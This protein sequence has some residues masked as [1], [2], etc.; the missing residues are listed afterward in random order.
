[1]IGTPYFLAFAVLVAAVAAVVDW[2]T[3]RIPNVLTLGALSLAPALHFCSALAAHGVSAGAT[4]AASSVLSAVVAALVPASLYF[5]ASAIGGGDVK[6]LAALGAVLGGAPGGLSGVMLGLE[7]ELNAFLA[8]AMIFPAR[9]AYE[10]RLG[11]VLLNTLALVA[12]P[13]LPAHRRRTLT[14]EMMTYA[15]FGP[16]VLVGVVVTAIS[17]WRQP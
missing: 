2:R 16:A 8:A 3:G 5:G 14:P 9:L 15:R 7:A 13:L 12:N 1:M 10:G 4:A 11:G 17:H 6:L